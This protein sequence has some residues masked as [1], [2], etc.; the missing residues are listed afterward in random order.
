MY[1]CFT[2]CAIALAAAA[3]PAHAEAPREVKTSVGAN[4]FAFGLGSPLSDADLATV[5]GGSS[6][7]FGLLNTQA[8]NEAEAFGRFTAQTL[9]VTFDNW[10]NDV[11]TPLI[12]ANL[13]R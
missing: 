13:S 9:P 5:R 7:R 1:S 10:F 8:R 6:S 11:V 4:P 12:A 2:L 3:V